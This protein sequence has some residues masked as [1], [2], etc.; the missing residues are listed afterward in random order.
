M[1]DRRV[2]VRACAV[3][4]RILN[5]YN[6][7]RDLKSVFTRLN[8]KRIVSSTIFVP[9]SRECHSHNPRKRSRK[10]LPLL[11]REYERFFFFILAFKFRAK[12]TKWFFVSTRAFRQRIV[13]TSRSFTE[14]PVTRRQKHNPAKSPPFRAL[15]CRLSSN[16]R[17][18]AHAWRTSL[19]ISIS[20]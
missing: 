13:S 4:S 16:V 17:N 11:V 19:T 8:I 2:F 1:R 18:I 6:T 15:F 10:Y 20:E 3:L 7:G 9:P 5:D 12:R 14:F